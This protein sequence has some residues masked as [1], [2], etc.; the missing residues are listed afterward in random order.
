MKKIY[1][2]T[3][4]ELMVA[5]AIVTVLAS[6]LLV[7]F[8]PNVQKSKLYLYSAINNIMRANIGVLD[9]YEKYSYA[10]ELF[11]QNTTDTTNGINTYCK[12]FADILALKTPPVCASNTA[13]TTTNLVL[14]NGIEIRGLTSAPVTPYT[15]S[16]FVYKNIMVDIDGF[17]SG[18]N[19]LWVDQF[20]LIVYSGGELTGNVQP[21]NCAT[22]NFYD[23]N[24]NAYTLS[25]STYCGSSSKNYTKDNSI[26]S[27]DVYYYEIN[28]SD[29]DAA[30]VGK[31][32]AASKTPFDADCIAYGGHGI[33][34]SKACQN[35]NL[36]ILE[37]CANE[38][39]CEKCN[40]YSTC[41][42]ATTTVAACTALNPTNARCAVRIHKPTSALSAMMRPLIGDLDEL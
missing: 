14:A 22:N 31:L 9:R 25:K 3:L 33:Y 10:G 34:Q 12:Q 35:A 26:L 38:F 41:A 15:D 1:G 5:I 27:Y 13:A 42:G 30:T 37:K 21:A 7:T 24:G 19:R 40:S 11:R 17:S 18:L 6:S 20:P 36:K 16:E 28:E 32:I 29:I 2:W 39:S 8:K 4:V 23:P